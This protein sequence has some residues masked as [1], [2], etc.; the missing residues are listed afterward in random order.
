[1]PTAVEP[2]H[3]VGVEYEN[4][5]NKIKLQTN[6]FSGLTELNIS[7]RANNAVVYGTNLVVDPKSKNN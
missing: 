7:R 4:A 1:M 5:A 3:K 6:I 2:S